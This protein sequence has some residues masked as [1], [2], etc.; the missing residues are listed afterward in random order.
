[1]LISDLSREEMMAMGLSICRY[2]TSSIRTRSVLHEDIRLSLPY[3][4]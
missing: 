4:K 3:S 2:P 1:L